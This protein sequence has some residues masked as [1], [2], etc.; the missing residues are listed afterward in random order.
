MD[1]AQVSQLI[2]QLQ[3]DSAETRYAAAEQLA[4][5]G[6]QARPAAAVLVSCSGDE[7]ERISEFAVAALE[8][9]GPP[10]DE[11]LAQLATL[12]GNQNPDVAYWA[13]TL[14][15]RLEAKGTGAVA[16]LVATLRSNP[17]LQVRQRVAWALGMIKH[18]GSGAKEALEQ[19]A[20][21]QDPRLARLARQ[22]LA[23][24]EGQAADKGH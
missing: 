23:E 15:G 1:A 21:S 14:L 22:A 20:A 19:A 24:I 5:C 4:R 17:H 7:D 11:A 2:Q 6:E 9:L 12:L 10:A 16:G 8:G 3:S 18:A 13:A